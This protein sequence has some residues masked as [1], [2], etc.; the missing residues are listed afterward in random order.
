MSVILSKWRRCQVRGEKGWERRMEQW[1]GGQQQRPGLLWVF[2]KYII[3]GPLEILDTFLSAVGKFLARE[4]ICWVQTLERLIWMSPWNNLFYPL[5]V[6]LRQELCNFNEGTMFSIQARW[7][8][9]WLLLSHESC[10]ALREVT[11]HRAVCLEDIM[12]G[13]TKKKLRPFACVLFS[14]FEALEFQ[15][16]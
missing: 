1:Q 8:L 10:K 4:P 3:M 9:S 7:C 11:M 2:S 13:C 15:S 6:I 5:F 16:S 14:Q 12:P